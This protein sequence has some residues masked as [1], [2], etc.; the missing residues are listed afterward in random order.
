MATV[1]TKLVRLLRREFSDLRRHL[2]IDRRDQSIVGYIV[3]PDF[4]RMT[5]AERQKRLW[6]VL[7]RHLDEAEMHWIGPIAALSPAEAETLPDGLA[8]PRSTPRG[9]KTSRPSKR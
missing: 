4:N 1:D 3:S 8:T 7:T 9:R 5:Y 2:H 6:N